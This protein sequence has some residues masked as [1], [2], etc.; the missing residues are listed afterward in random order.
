YL[1]EAYRVA[2]AQ[3]A[4]DALETLSAGFDLARPLIYLHRTAEAQRLLAPDIP[5]D[6]ESGYAK[7]MRAMRVR[8]LGE[9]ELESGQYALA[10]KSFDAAAADFSTF[11][12]PDTAAIVKLQESQ[13]WLLYQEKKFDDAAKMLRD[14]LTQYQRLYPADSAYTQAASVE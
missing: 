14:V 12:A 11:K 2:R 9:N 4:Q 6:Q 8:W 10:T 7:Y 1:R 3:H 13:G 5:P